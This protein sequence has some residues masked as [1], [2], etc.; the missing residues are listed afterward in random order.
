M[1]VHGTVNAGVVGS[2]PTWSV[3]IMNSFLTFTAIVF[4]LFYSILVY[5]HPKG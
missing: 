4:Y 5:F 3:N 1:V 2:S